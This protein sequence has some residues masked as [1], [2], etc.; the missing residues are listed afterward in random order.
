MNF[1]EWIEFE[2]ERIAGMG[3]LLPEG[4][5]AGYIR[6]QIESALRK[7]FVHGRDGLTAMDPP[8]AVSRISN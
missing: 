3:L 4:Q 5:R 8:R 7:A 1:S 2:A 6:V